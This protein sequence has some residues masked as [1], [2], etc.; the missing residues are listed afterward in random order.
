MKNITLLITV[1]SL[2]L[3]A[4]LENSPQD[5]PTTPSQ[6][7]RPTNT[8]TA[9]PTSSPTPTI[10]PSIPLKLEE[11]LFPWPPPV[12]TDEKVA[13]SK[14]CRITELYE[15]RYLDIENP[16]PQNIK[17]AYEPQDDCDW[18][19]LLTLLAEYISEEEFAEGD[20]L[21]I[22]QNLIHQNPGLVFSSPAIFYIANNNIEISAAPPFTKQ[23]LELVDIVYEWNG[24][25]TPVSFELTIQVEQEAWITGNA[26]YGPG[27][28]EETGST[29]TLEF[30]QEIPLEIIEPF[31]TRLNNLI[32]VDSQGMFFLCFDNYPDWEI[33]LQYVDGTSINL[34]T[35]ESNIF[36]MGAP[37]QTK[38]G[39]QNY[40]LGSIDFLDAILELVNFL[41]LSLG[42]PAATY[43]SSENYTEVVFPNR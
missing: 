31:G 20:D 8:P 40:I 21:V 43:C 34:V 32:P 19:L 17:A 30:D 37:F 29:T 18:A 25:G 4:C 28:D 14:D 10:T 36:Y 3:S 33:T 41:E 7:P 39:D 23:E 9:E 22:L 1:F 35:N 15:E 2:L 38:I 13:V 42:S 16:N 11:P 27:W 26:T 12:L 6:T 5:L 24:I